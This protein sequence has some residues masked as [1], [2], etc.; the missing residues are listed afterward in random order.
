MPLL[1][2]T[3]RGF[4]G[5]APR[6]SRAFE[7]FD[8]GRGIRDGLFAAERISGQL[9]HFHK[10]NSLI[11]AGLTAPAPHSLNGSCLKIICLEDCGE[12]L[13]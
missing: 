12:D 8:G 2:A 13:L 7:A 5:K 3:T 10:H 11:K 9:P 1:P 4:L 6:A